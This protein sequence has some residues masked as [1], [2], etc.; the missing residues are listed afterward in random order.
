[1]VHIPIKA[2]Y[3]KFELLLRR[4]GFEYLCNAYMRDGMFFGPLKGM[5][6]ILSKDWIHFRPKQTI[7]QLG[8]GHMVKDYTN[9]F[10]SNRQLYQ[11][12][13]DILDLIFKSKISMQDFNSDIWNSMSNI[14]ERL[15][16]FSAIYTEATH[17]PEAWSEY[18]AIHPE[19]A[20]FPNW[21]SRFYTI[22]YRRLIVPD[23]SRYLAVHTEEARLIKDH[24]NK[25]IADSLKPFLE[26]FEP[27]L[28][29]NIA[30]I[31]YS[32]IP[33]VVIPDPVPKLIPE[34][35]RFIIAG[36]LLFSGL[37]IA[38]KFSMPFYTLNQGVKFT[39][40]YFNSGNLYEAVDKFIDSIG[41]VEQNDS[42]LSGIQDTILEYVPDNPIVKATVIEAS[43][44]LLAIPHTAEILYGECKTLEWF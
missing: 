39:K 12:A 6:F 30:T 23:W 27:I 25:H 13:Y 37:S 44:F 10:E 28:D 8:I 3:D 24:I 15:S 4:H 29:R 31:I 42:G 35:S 21:W 14:P 2:L 1:M 19:E 38:M 18:L 7:E 40:I 9:F 36:K 34:P 26:M 20:N 16:E 22:H 5:D 11:I 41:T 43:S 32:Y 33:G 17:I